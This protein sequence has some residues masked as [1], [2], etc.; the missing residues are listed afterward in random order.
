MET[1]SIRTSLNT[2]HIESLDSELISSRI[3][4]IDEQAAHEIKLKKPSNFKANIIVT[5]QTE[6]KDISSTGQSQ[7]K[8]D[9]DGLT[10]N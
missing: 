9:M 6:I 7:S 4:A 3:K 10:P 5:H 1:A 8:E 2:N